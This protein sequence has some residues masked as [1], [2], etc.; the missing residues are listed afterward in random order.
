MARKPVAEIPTESILAVYA[1]S[2]P[3]QRAA[4]V[5]WYAEANRV[6]RTLSERYGVTVEQAAGVIAAVSPLNSW[7]ANVNLATRII[8]AGGM[9]NGYLGVGLRKAN[10]ILMGLDPVDVLRSQKVAAFY[11]GIIS[12]GQTD[13]VCV[14]RHS[15]SVAVGERTVNVPS[16]TPARYVALQS[17][18]V[19]AA[20]TVPGVSPA[21]LQAITWLAWRARYWAEGA[22]DPKGE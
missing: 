13:A 10:A 2:T 19:R 7:G 15:Y 1:D 16:I 20:A 21:E 11:Q 5:A 17:A 9:L 22:F 14:D 18:Y 6:A 12:N 8:A 3:A 4:G